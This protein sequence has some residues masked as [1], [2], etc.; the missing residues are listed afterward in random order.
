MRMQ[1][2]RANS[3]GAGSLAVLVAALSACATAAPVEPELSSM[4]LAASVS[5]KMGVPV[6]LRYQ[7]DGGVQAGTPV[8]LHLAAVPRVAGTNLSVSV[9]KEPGIQTTA[10]EVRS[11]KAVATTAYRQQLSVTRLSNGPSELRV[12]VTMDLPQG[13]AFS[14][15][16]IPLDGA[17]AAQKQDPVRKE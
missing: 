17:P 7:F 15:Y 12:L 8:T 13:S 11:Q 3:L 2:S 16:S 4:K 9:R 5:S 10:A 14:Y 6:D 1:L